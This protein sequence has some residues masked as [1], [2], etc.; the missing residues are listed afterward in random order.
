MAE[1]SRTLHFQRESQTSGVRLYTTQGEVTNP[2]VIT[3][4][5]TESAGTLYTTAADDITP[6]LRLKDGSTTVYAKLEE[7]SGTNKGLKVSANEKNYV[8]PSTVQV[9]LALIASGGGAGTWKQVDAEGNSL[10]GAIDFSNTYPW[11]AI[12]TVTIDGQT[13]VKIPKFYVKYGE[14]QSGSNAGKKARWV[15]ETKKTGYHIHPAFVKNGYVMDSFYLGAYEAYNSG[16]NKAGSAANK[17][18]WVNIGG[19]ANAKT[20]CANRGAGWHLQNIYEIAAV[21]ILL[22][23]ELGTPDVQTAIA[24]GNVRSSA[25]VTTGSSAAVWRGI[26]EWWGNMMEH[27]DGLTTDANGIYQIF[28]N[29]MDG[30]YVSTG[31]TNPASG[32][33]TEMSEAKGT[34]FDLSDVFLSSATNDTVGNGTYGDYHFTG[35]NTILLRS[36]YWGNGGDAGAFEVSVYNDALYSENSVCL[37][38]AKEGT[39]TEEVA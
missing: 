12:E 3:D 9:G 13:M 30:S 34:N 16:S 39:V 31:I 21:N 20:Y 22:L 15:S 28:S 4:A 19:F 1:H 37:R 23:I 10:S 25:V 17:T 7:V 24:A 8:A 27:V 36:G 35:K 26:H 29:K 38:L 18:P 2:T 6:A 14:I 33:I 11:N 32:W 5:S